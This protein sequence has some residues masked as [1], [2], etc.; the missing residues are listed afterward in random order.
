MGVIALHRGDITYG[1]VGTEKRLDF[2]VIG[3]AVNEAARIESMCKILNWPVLV[4]SYFAQSVA[5]KLHSL[6]EHTLQGVRGKQEI[7][8]LPQTI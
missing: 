8:T 2:T 1:N 3:P 4:S 7:F 5:S 6:G